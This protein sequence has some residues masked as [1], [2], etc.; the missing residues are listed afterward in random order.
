M[1]VPM[2]DIEEQTYQPLRVR[3]VPGGMSS[4]LGWL[5]IIDSLIQSLPL[6]VK[7]TCLPASALL[8]NDSI[9]IGIKKSCSIPASL[10]MIIFSGAIE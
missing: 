6:Y 2:L 10:W 9:I 4:S 5:F 7:L 8:T 1:Y 3:I